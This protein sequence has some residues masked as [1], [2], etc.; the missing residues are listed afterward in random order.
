[1][2][3]G[4]LR[5]AHAAQRAHLRRHV[6]MYS[7]A[8]PTPQC[9]QQEQQRQG[10]RQHGKRAPARPVTVRRVR[11][12]ACRP[13]AACARAAPEQAK[14]TLFH[15]PA[16]A[17]WVVPVLH[18]VSLWLL[19]LEKAGHAAGGAVR[20]RLA[21]ARR[22]AAALCRGLD[23]QHA[24]RHAARVARAPLCCCGCPESAVWMTAGSG[25]QLCVCAAADR[26][27][28]GGGGCASSGGACVSV[29]RV[30]GWVLAR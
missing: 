24:R 16:R 11:H 23:N 8:R 9:T 28:R 26:G 14:R 13:H 18:T 19:G 22:T 3:H 20:W 15:E 30:R 1:M 29:V 7:P 17:L 4:R 21:A 25:G 6:L 27:R 2:H 12:A 5:A 10:R